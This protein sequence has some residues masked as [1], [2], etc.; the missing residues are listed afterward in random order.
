M[1]GRR[2]FLRML[3]IVAAAPAIGGTA[4]LAS[5]SPIAPVASDEPIVDGWPAGQ[6]CMGDPDEA[7]L[8]HVVEVNGRFRVLLREDRTIEGVVVSDPDF[9]TECAEGE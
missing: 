6:F 7:P 4:A 1:I 9:D 8:F 3:G 2:S 5:V